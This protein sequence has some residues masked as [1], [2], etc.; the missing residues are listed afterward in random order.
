ME[1]RLSRCHLNIKLIPQV[2]PVNGPITK[3]IDK[4]M[5]NDTLEKMESKLNHMKL[6]F[7]R[8]EE[9]KIFIKILLRF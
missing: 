1:M 9:T 8:K 7:T 4:K 6:L 5:N 3:R 2:Y